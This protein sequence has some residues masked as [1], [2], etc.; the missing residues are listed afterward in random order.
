MNVGVLKE[1]DPDEK[2]VALVPETVKKL[3]ARKL[4]PVIERGAGRSAGFTD[5]EYEAAGATLSD[6]AGVIMAGTL[7]AVTRPSLPLLAELP[8]RT[9]VVSLQ[10][11]LTSADFVR[12]A[13][14]RKLRTIA[15]DMIPRITLAQGMDVLSS[16]ANFAGYWAV[17]AAAARLPK[18]FPLLMTAAG[19]IAPARVFIMGVGVAGLQAIGTARRLGAVVEATDVRPETKEQV[20]SLGGKFV[21]STAS[22]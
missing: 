5:A 16:Q 1:I 19:T 8:E 21:A 14:Q 3:V 13:N 10:Y 6:R 20:E 2:R 18:I 17:V 9:A 7:L 22:Q 4:Q 15:L 11:P 12:A